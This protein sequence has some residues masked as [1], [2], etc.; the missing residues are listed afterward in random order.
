VSVSGVY[1]L[2]TPF[3]GPS[4]QVYCD[5]DTAGGPWMLL[6]AY[7]HIGGENNVLV[8][9]TVPISPTAGYSHVN[10]N[11]LVDGNGK[12]IFKEASKVR[13]Y[14]QT[15]GHSRKIHFY[16]SNSVIDQMTYDGNMAGNTPSLWNTG[17]TPLP[18]HSAYLPASTYHAYSSNSLTHFPFYDENG[19][20]WGIRANGFRWE[21]D[22]AH[23]NNGYNTLHQIWVNTGNT[24]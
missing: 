1:G 2:V 5:I 13:F 23:H 18:G 11:A 8:P 7:N 12:A 22:D 4:Y 14:C 19:H 16:T 6:Y 3:N 9:G 10:L 24:K 15:S 20:I 21:C 17:Y